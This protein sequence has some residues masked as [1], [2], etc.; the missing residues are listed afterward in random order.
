MSSHLDQEFRARE[1]ADSL[2]QF[3]MTVNSGA[4]AI[5]FSI[6]GISLEKQ[7]SANWVI[8]PA[9]IFVVGIIFCIGSNFMAHHR[10]LKRRDAAKDNLPEPNFCFLQ[11]SVTWNLASS[12]CFVAGVLAALYKLQSI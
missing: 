11:K 9:M 5:L 1:L 3:L 12:V 2:R 10:A 8:V 6:A 4:V 7:C